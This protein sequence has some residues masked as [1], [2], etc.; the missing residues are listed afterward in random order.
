MATAVSPREFPSTACKAVPAVAGFDLNVRLEED[1][2]G[3]VPFHLNE[4]ILEDHNVNEHAVQNQ[5]PVEGQHRRK[6]MTEEVTKQ[7]Y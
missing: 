5:A 1:E 7:V 2:D 6:D 3:N 4:P